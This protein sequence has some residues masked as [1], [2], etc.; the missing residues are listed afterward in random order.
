[1]EMPRKTLTAVGLD[2]L[3]WNWMMPNDR[4]RAHGLSERLRTADLLTLQYDRMVGRAWRLSPQG[5]ECLNRA[6]EANGGPVPPRPDT[7]A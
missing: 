6:L 1:M 2:L 4:C 5:V 3:H 7:S